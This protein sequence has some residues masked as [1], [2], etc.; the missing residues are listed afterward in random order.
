MSDYINSPT[1]VVF[2]QGGQLV[3]ESSGL[4]RLTGS[5]IPCRVVLMN[6]RDDTNAVHVG[7]TSV[8][9]SLGVIVGKYD[10]IRLQID[11]VNK[12]WIYASTAAS[13]FVTYFR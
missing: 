1:D 5:S 12:V 4:Y 2:S 7:V 6:V 8:N 11:D 10:P 13:V 3:G 9:T